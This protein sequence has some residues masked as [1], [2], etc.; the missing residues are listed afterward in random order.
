MNYKTA[1][2]VSLNDKK[3]IKNLLDNYI[4]DSK[5]EIQLLNINDDLSEMWTFKNICC[6]IH[7]P[8]VEDERGMLCDID[9]VMDAMSPDS[10]YYDYYQTV[11]EFLKQ[12]KA[13]F[14]THA[15]KS[16]KEVVEHKNYHLFLD[17]LRKYDVK[18]LVENVTVEV[19]DNNKA[20]DY[21]IVL[22]RQINDD[23]GERKAY[24]LFDICHFM[25]L[26]AGFESTIKINL[27]DAVT[28]YHSSNFFIHFNSATGSG[29]SRTGGKHSFN[30]SD[31]LSLLDS[32]LD[33]L[34]PFDPTLILE[35]NEDDMFEKPRARWLK[36]YIK[37]YKS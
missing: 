31:N 14:V 2:K 32:L 21:P 26:R 34:Q 7:G 1:F 12:T 9:R 10:D 24:P 13:G 23:L 16:P 18:L 20:I 6:S 17:Y 25:M 37:S 15:T 36:N 4:G 5:V 11:G 35:C 28:M 33:Y 3:V 22:T 19:K 30:F 27:K 8:L 29:D